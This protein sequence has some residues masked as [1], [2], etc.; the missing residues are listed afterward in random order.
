MWIKIQWNVSMKNLDQQ[1]LTASSFGRLQH[2]QEA[3]RSCLFEPRFQLNAQ[4]YYLA[5]IRIDEFQIFLSVSHE[6]VAV[7]S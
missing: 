7:D 2:G 4:R 3:Q 6:R 1:L 5:Q